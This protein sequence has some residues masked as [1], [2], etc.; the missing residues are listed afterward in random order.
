MT[1]AQAIVCDESLWQIIDVAKRS[2]ENIVALPHELLG[3]PLSL[4]RVPPISESLLS[5]DTLGEID[6]TL[7]VSGLWRSLGQCLR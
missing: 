3:Q 1:R 6:I 4:Q 2:L 7:C 5:W